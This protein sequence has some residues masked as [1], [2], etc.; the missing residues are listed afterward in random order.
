MVY[1]PSQKIPG[2]TGSL[3]FSASLVVESYFFSFKLHPK[4]LYIPFHYYCFDLPVL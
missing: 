3:R 2:A 4:G 1:D